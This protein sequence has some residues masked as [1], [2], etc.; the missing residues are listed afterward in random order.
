MALKE[1]E[2]AVEKS[3]IFY[4]YLL[5]EDQKAMATVTTSDDGIQYIRNEARGE[6]AVVKARKAKPENEW[7]ELLHLKSPEMTFEEPADDPEE[8]FF[9]TIGK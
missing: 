8:V 9:F 6:I 2:I 7:Y 3:W 4:S 5:V 1:M